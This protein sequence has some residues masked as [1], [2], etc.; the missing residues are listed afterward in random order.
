M[1]QRSGINRGLMWLRKVLQITEETESPRVLSEIVGPTID[2]FGWSRLGPDQQT[3]TRT[4]GT[5]VDVIESPVVPDDVVRLITA[6][7]V[8]T[9]NAVLAFTLWIEL[10]NGTGAGSISIIRPLEIPISAVPIKVGVER[11]HVL[12]PGERL[13]GRSSPATGVGSDL[14]IYQRFIDLPFGEYVGYL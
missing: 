7:C 11:I 6:A 14:R 2:T 12:A 5:N 8:E 10:S 9:N 13:R 3:F 4:V 1:A